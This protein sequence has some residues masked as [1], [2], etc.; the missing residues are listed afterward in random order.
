MVTENPKIFRLAASAM[1]GERATK[2]S[3]VYYLP[4]NVGS[5]EHKPGQNWHLN[6]DAKIMLNYLI[7]QRH[8]NQLQ[9][10]FGPTGASLTASNVRQG[11]LEGLGLC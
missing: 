3:A 2:R 9:P 1:T 10:T 8:N 7:D 6:T 4:K 11:Q 5:G